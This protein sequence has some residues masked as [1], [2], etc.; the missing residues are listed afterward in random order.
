MANS[1][2][3]CINPLNG[4]HQIPGSSYLD[5]LVVLARFFAQGAVLC[6][7]ENHFK[8]ECFGGSLM[9]PLK[10]AH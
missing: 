6:L 4:G 2:N 8:S 3:T 7:A 9:N 5:A 1:L 10:Y